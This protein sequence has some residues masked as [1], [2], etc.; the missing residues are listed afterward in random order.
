MNVKR[1]SGQRWRLVY[2]RNLFRHFSRTNSFP[3]LKEIL[4]TKKMSIKRSAFFNFLKIYFFHTFL[5]QYS[6]FGNAED[7]GLVI[8]EFWILHLSSIQ[9]VFSFLWIGKSTELMLVSPSSL[10]Q[11]GCVHYISKK[12]Q[13]LYFKKLI[14][15]PWVI[16]QINISWLIS[17]G[18]FLN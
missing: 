17:T 3:L 14:N 7:G 9:S 6:F 2:N 5:S 13:D 18:T 15:L 16:R 4:C 12:T 8:D 11:L 10:K 1:F